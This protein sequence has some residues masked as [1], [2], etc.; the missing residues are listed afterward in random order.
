M[1]NKYLLKQLHSI[2]CESWFLYFTVNLNYLQSFLQHS[3]K[4]VSLIQFQ[5]TELTY[6]AN[7]K[8]FA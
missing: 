7:T 3:S 5:T 2:K 1:Q 8:L 4:K 6:N